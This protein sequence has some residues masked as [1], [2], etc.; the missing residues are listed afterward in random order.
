MPP[1]RSPSRPDPAERGVTL[2]EIMIALMVLAIGVLALSRVFPAGSRA[3][4]SAKLR[5]EASQL[6]R[7]KVEQLQVLGWSDAALS[8]GRHPPGIAAEVLNTAGSLRRFYTVDTLPSPLAN[9]KILT[10]SVAFHES[11]GCTVQAVSYL[12]K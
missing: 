2:T 7:E 3:Q 12:R 8:I 9:L 11:K 5:A 4:V 1:N 10:V 6:S